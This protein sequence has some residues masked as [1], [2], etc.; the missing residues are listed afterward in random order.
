MALKRIPHILLCVLAS[1]ALCGSARAAEWT[2]DYSA[3][4]ARAKR[5]NKL[6]L[7][8][9]TGSDWCSWCRKTDAEVF[10][11]DKFQKFA[12]KRLILVKVD[13]P[14]H[15]QLPF[16]LRLQN[17]DLKAKYAIQGYPTLIVLDPQ[18]RIVVRQ[19]GYDEGGPEAFI[20]K[21]PKPAN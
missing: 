1:V 16:D 10:S 12:D 11:T 8:D 20:A 4:L 19:D 21:F 18:E 9:F 7:L 15:T 17:G 14:R 5:E 13:F 3:A 6:V 2:E